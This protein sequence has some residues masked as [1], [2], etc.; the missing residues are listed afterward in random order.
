MVLPEVYK[1]LSVFVIGGLFVHLFD[2]RKSSLSANC[3][4]ESER[5]QGFFVDRRSVLLKRL[6]LVHVVKH[7]LYGVHVYIFLCHC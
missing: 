2:V 1:H 5:D 7:K 3:L 6:P 4:V